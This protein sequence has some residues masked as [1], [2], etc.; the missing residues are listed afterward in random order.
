MRR[1]QRTG[2]EERGSSS[3]VYTLRWSRYA[4][5][6]F[7]SAM[8][9][10]AGVVRDYARAIEGEGRKDGTEQGSGRT[11]MAREK[12]KAGKGGVE[13]EEGYRRAA[14]GCVGSVIDLQQGVSLA[15]ALLLS[16]PFSLFSSLSRAHAVEPFIFL[17]DFLSLSLSLFFLPSIDPHVVSLSLAPSIPTSLSFVLFISFSQSALAG[18]IVRA[19]LPFRLTL[20][21]LLTL[22]HS[23]THIHTHSLS[24]SFS[25]KIPHLL[26]LRSAIKRQS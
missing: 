18:A 13:Q 7:R 21:H 11:G 6:R 4:G 19:L 20:S 12:G 8:A 25:S 16:F 2:E 5:V 9:R 24:L 3:W 26:N 14:R 1:R 17:I 23:H 15:R 10:M 22:T